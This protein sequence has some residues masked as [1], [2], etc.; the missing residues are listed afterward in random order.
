MQLNLP[1]R[2]AMACL[3]LLTSISCKN[4]YAEVVNTESDY[5]I[6]PRP[7]N[8]TPATG[9][10]VLDEVVYIVTDS[11]TMTEAEYL[12]G[13]LTEMLPGSEVRLA[14]TPE[15]GIANILLT[16]QDDASKEEGSYALRVNADRAEITANTSKGIFYGIQTIRQLIDMPGALENVPYAS[17][18][19][20]N[21]E[22]A[23]RFGYRGMH[24]DVARH[25]QPVTFIKK[26]IDLLAMHK[27][28]TFHW[29]LTE[30][31]GW[32]IEIKKYPRLT[33][34][35]AWR[36]GTVVGKLPW[37]ENDNER[38]GGFYTQ[39]EIREIV[40]YAQARHITVIPEI[41]LPGHSSAAIA[42]YPELSC[43]PEEPT[44][45]KRGVLADK[46]RAL[47][48]AG[49][50]KVVYEEWGVTDDVYCAGKESTF[51]FITG[52]LDE[53][54]ELFPSAYIH[55]GG[56]ECPK[57]NWK[58]CGQC[59][60]RIREEG[61]ADE[62]EL[63]SYFIQRV[64]KYLNSKGKQIIGW[65]EILEGGLAPHATVMYWRSWLGDK[66]VLEAAAQGHGVIMT[67][68]SHMYFD[69][70]QADPEGEPEAICCLSTVENVYSYEPVP[71]GMDPGSAKYILGA[72]ANVWTE[73][74]KEADKIEYMVLPRMAAL[75]EVLWTPGSKRDYPDFVKRMEVLRTIYD[76]EQYHYAGH[77]FQDSIHVK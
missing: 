19:A 66:E 70:Y 7:V 77:I 6:V 29:H 26:Y 39:E 69:H 64:E 45:P 3:G 56:D 24:L 9:R 27:M 2:I 16:V 11:E 18:P 46:S 4:P 62:H 35:G 25:F 73:Y 48:E 20:V 75:A 32:R 30:D 37:T 12:R 14:A 71:Q 63:Q 13:L 41:E 50:A 47:Q 23:P 10:F 21:I 1:L 52:V 36:N 61:L 55:I 31:Q 68:S 59:Q 8:L 38:Y 49:Q 67:P 43:F 33:E 22:D 51:E 65:D 34:V 60:K 28:N 5:H 54:V 58:R 74:M 72:Q 44:T 76:K 17:I 42:S 57:G 53:V 15:K 40:A